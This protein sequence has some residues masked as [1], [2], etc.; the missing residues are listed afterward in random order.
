ME[1]DRCRG[2]R[3]SA[4]FDGVNQAGFG[5][6]ANYSRRGSIPHSTNRDSPECAPVIW[7]PS[8]S[9][10]RCTR[11]RI[12]IL[13]QRDDRKRAGTS[14]GESRSSPEREAKGPTASISLVSRHQA[15]A[16]LC[17]TRTIRFLADAKR[18]ERLSRI[19]RGYSRSLM[20]AIELSPKEG[21]MRAT[22]AHSVRDDALDAI[23]PLAGTLAAFVILIGIVIF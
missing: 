9:R 2:H 16:P 10:T 23:L 21:L 12:R 19:S 5:S 8:R 15:P 20:R 3:A 14:L 13:F 11:P 22:R 6:P 7:M 4:E 18:G 17:S 1:S